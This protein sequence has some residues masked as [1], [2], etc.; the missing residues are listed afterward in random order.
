M[1]FEFSHSA[2]ED[3]IAT[4]DAL[5]V[6]SAADNELILAA[7]QAA[8]HHL[9]IVRD[10]RGVVLE[11][12]PGAGRIYVNARP[13]RERALLREGDV[14]S[15]GD[16]RMFLR[17]DDDPAQREA[18]VS[19]GPGRCPASLRAVAGPLSGRVMRIDDTLELGPLGHHPL[20][21]PHNAVAALRIGWKDGVLMLESARNESRFPLR[22]NG[23]AVERAPLRPDD[24]IGIAMHRFVLDAPGLLA[25]PP[26]AE[27]ELDP[28]P[29]AAAGPR[30]EVWWLIATA[31]VLALA[32]ALM[33]LIRF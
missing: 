7:H 10:A 15:L 26:V 4:K 32:I 11:V 17:S 19:P 31:A 2:R 24:Q 8:P 6:G 1:R 25:E 12:L 13:V 14:L 18:I 22:L 5:R 29:E 30:G 28:A 20:E 27:P 16:C 9:R 23:V 33:L 21:L 3:F